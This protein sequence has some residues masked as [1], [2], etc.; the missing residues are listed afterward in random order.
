MRAP[1]V[2]DTNVFVS[3]DYTQR[4]ERLPGGYLLTA[5]VLQELLAGRRAPEQQTL[6]DVAKRL[7]T[8]GRLIV[9]D[10][11]DWIQ[12]GVALSRLL[13]GSARNRRTPSKAEVNLLVRDTLIARCAVKLGATVVTSNIDDFVRIKQVFRSLK[14]VTPSEYFETRPR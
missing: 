11:E 2:F 10:R 9:P 8:L 3:G 13:R 4:I 7:E 6:C 5:V 12:V 1:P 14:F